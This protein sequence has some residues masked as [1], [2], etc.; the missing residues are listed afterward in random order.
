M[1]LSIIVIPVGIRKCIRLRVGHP[2]E[3]GS[4]NELE[5]VPTDYDLD[6]S[7]NWFHCRRYHF[8][9]DQIGRLIVACNGK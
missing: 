9:V 1:A 2:L 3:R 4:R 8:M 6:F 5:R 7:N